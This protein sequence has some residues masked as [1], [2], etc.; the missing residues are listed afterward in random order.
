VHRHTKVDQQ[1]TSVTGQTIERIFRYAAVT[2]YLE[3]QNITVFWS[4]KLTWEYR[5]MYGKWM[6]Y[7]SQHRST[8]RLSLWLHTDNISDN[9]FTIE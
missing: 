9:D 6:L 1:L 5:K 2:L 7:I 4:M 8:F 3:I